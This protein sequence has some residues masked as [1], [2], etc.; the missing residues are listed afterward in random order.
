[1]QEVIEYIT[2]QV[3]NQI[4]VAEELVLV[5]FAKQVNFSESSEKTYFVM[6]ILD[7]SCVYNEYDNLKSTFKYSAS[8]K[9][10][11][12]ALTNLTKKI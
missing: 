12:E 3:A 10:Y 5:S 6:I 11:L 8:G 4:G 2:K 7:E 1:M 9:T